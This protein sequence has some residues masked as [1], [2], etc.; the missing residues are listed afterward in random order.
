MKATLVGRKVK[1]L[2]VYS[3]NHVP[4]LHL[5]VLFVEIMLVNSIIW[6]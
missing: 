4:L 1:N 2:I 6:R 5:W 3:R